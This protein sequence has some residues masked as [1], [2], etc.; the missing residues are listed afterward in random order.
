VKRFLVPAA[1]AA[2][3][4]AGALAAG[5]S[6]QPDQGRTLTLFEDVPHEFSALVDN[7]PRSP[8]KSPDSR[9]F[10]LSPGDELV[11]RAPL[12]ERRHGRRVGTS[13]VHAAVV[14]GRRFE[15]ATLQAD[16]LLALH[17]GTLA[18]AGLAGSR[19]R[20]FAVVG[21]TG[22]YQ[23]AAGSATERE[24]A[25]GAELTIRLEP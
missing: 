12:L 9:R 14:S 13:Y 25:G 7:A 20:P 1:G 23:G 4:A 22:A 18:L 5:G 10:R 3:V 21:G 15:K 11:G 16:V 6:A 8:A 17:D 2:L 24:V 19:Q